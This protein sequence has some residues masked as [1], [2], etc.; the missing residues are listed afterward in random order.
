MLHLPQHKCREI[1][2]F[3]RYC[4]KGC[5]VYVAPDGSEVMFAAGGPCVAFELPA[6]EAGEKTT[7]PTE[8]PV[9]GLRPARGHTQPGRL[10]PLTPT[11]RGEQDDRQDDLARAAQAQEQG[12]LK[13][14][15]TVT[16]KGKTFVQLTVPD[17]RMPG[18]RRGQDRP[19]GGRLMARQDVIELL[20]RAPR[21]PDRRRPADAVPRS[22]RVLGG[23]A[24][25]SRQELH[26]RRLRRRSKPQPVRQL[27]RTDRER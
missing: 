26:A 25:G 18:G 19:G 3:L 17:A 1:E 24:R 14:G 15:Q 23:R 27:G 2:E 20:D 13:I 10:R 5:D 22:D 8:A 9:H 7:R 21:R 4:V 11:T 6:P 12:Q 16:S